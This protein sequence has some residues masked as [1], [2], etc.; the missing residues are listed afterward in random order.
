M[1]NGVLSSVHPLAT[2]VAVLGVLAVASFG[3]RRA[4]VR[5]RITP[6]GARQAM[7]ASTCAVAIAMPWLFEDLWPVVLVAAISI[8]VVSWSNAARVIL[9]GQDGNR[10]WAIGGMALPFAVVGL[11]VMTASSP[12]LY[13]IPFLLL[14][15]AEPAAALTGE[16]H[17][18]VPYAT[19]T[20]TKSREG[21]VA[22]AFV[23]FLCVH[24]PLLVLTPVGRAE[25][26]WI[27]A[28]VA[29]LATIVEA[30]TWGGLV[31]LF[32]PVGTYVVMVRLLTLDAPA[33]AGHF[34][35]LVGLVTAAAMLRRETTVGGA[36]VFGAAL[37]GYLAW[38]L[39][40]TAW[41]L[42]PV[43]VYA[44]Y[45]RVWPVAREADGLPHDPERRPHTA[46]NV[47]SV[48]AVSVAWLLLSN[49]V[50]TELLFPYALGWAVS[51]TYLGVERML[52]AR[53]GWTIGQL[54]WRASWRATLVAV[55]PVLLVIWLRV[56]ADAV[57]EAPVGGAAA[58][59][60]PFM[61]TVA[62]LGIGL[63]VTSASATAFTLWRR[64]QWS[65][66]SVGEE[67]LFRAAVAAPLTA[68][69]LLAL[70]VP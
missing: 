57:S 49:V 30:V 6:A 11:F 24:V 54:A 7:L 3:I 35:V 50:G 43:L 26:L 31:H 25:A 44:L 14:G 68:L 36:G 61:L 19:A 13:A 64:S 62:F 37:V 47:F 32:V 38:A 21:S 16:R 39:G 1:G 15:L 41:L 70:L 29:V 69:G 53:S 10:R 33:L 48:S 9:P 17:G 8:A 22:F 45:A 52:F 18:L 34:L 60:E 12:V 42:S 56:A 46:L 59:D 40:G 66:V 63:V 5:R 20:G 27:A 65:Q 4:Q 55:V 28:I 2:A 51:L 58:P 23:A 67:R